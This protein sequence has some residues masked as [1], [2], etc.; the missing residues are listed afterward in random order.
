MSIELLKDIL[1]INFEGKLFTDSIE[2]TRFLNSIGLTSIN[3]RGR[4]KAYLEQMQR[5][6]G[7]EG[8]V[9]PTDSLGRPTMVGD[10]L[11]QAEQDR[12]AGLV[13]GLEEE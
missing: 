5:E 1:V 11:P 9:L 3:V 8:A 4:E 2:A 10:K 6:Q 7:L 12:I 13:E